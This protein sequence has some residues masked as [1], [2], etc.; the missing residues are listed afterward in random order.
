MTVDICL[1]GIAR[2]DCDYHKPTL[3][4]Q[5]TI[6]INYPVHDVTGTSFIVGVTNFTAENF[7][8]ASSLLPLGSSSADKLI[9]D[10]VLYHR[11][12]KC[13]LVDVY[14]GITSFQGILLKTKPAVTGAIHLSD[15]H[16]RDGSVVGLLTREH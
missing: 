5:T 11:L 7:Y 4:S 9:V 1:C 3:V 16:S 8:D 15:I 14:K 10:L 12:D 2:E 6:G 13:N